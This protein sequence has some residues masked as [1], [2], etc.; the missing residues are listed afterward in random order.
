MQ[1][2]TI[3]LQMLEDRP[4][5]KDRLRQQ[6]QMLLML[7]VYAEQLKAGHETWKERLS[8]TRPGGDPMQIASEAMEL[9]LAELEERLPSES[10]AENETFSLDAAMAFHHRHLSDD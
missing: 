3:V 5:L 4:R 7:E 6:R 8:P 9:A 10:N 1:Y 2:K